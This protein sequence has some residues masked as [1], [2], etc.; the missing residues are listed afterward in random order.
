[1]QEQGSREVQKKTLAGVMKKI[2]VLKSWHI[3]AKMKNMIIGGVI[4]E[5]K[6]WAG[7]CAAIGM[8]ESLSESSAAFE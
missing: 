7:I 2:T 1:M 6:R 4:H 5:R 3:E 8:R